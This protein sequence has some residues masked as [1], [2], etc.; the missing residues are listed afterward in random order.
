MQRN[1]SISIDELA[2]MSGQTREEWERDYEA[3]E[4]ALE[5]ATDCQ[6]RCSDARCR[7]PTIGIDRPVPNAAP[8]TVDRGATSTRRD[9]P[10][11]GAR[12]ARI[13]SRQIRRSLDRDRRRAGAG[14]VRNRRPATRILR[15][16]P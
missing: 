8:A 6:C 7:P 1:G 5:L 12:M 10:A 16:R 9:L 2:A 14:R 4:K 3:A 11:S 13:T 15:R